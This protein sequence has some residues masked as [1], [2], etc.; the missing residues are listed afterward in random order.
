MKTS[1]IV[2]F[3]V[4]HRTAEADQDPSTTTTYL[5]ASEN[6]T[7][8]PTFRMDP[9]FTTAF[10]QN[11]NDGTNTTGGKCLIDSKM[12]PIAI[13][14][15]AGFIICLLITISVLA[16][17][18][19]VLQRRV[20]I[21]GTHRSDT[22]MM[23]GAHYWGPDQTEIEGLVGPC[24]TTVMLEEVMTDDHTQSEIQDALEE[25]GAGI[26]DPGEKNIQFQSS[27]SRDSCVVL[28]KDLEDMPLVV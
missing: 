16:C 2:L 25:A 17:Q 12:G 19:W 15:A 27:S 26:Q 13:G 22:D 8:T 21:P 10:Q 24:D 1:L 6:L 5:L 3:L 11:P 14:S 9:S 28:P 18:I 7:D 4:L 20:Y 23:G